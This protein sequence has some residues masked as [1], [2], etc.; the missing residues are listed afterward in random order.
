M[1]NTTELKPADK[2]KII[3]DKC[4]ASVH[5]GVNEHKSYYEPVEDYIAQRE[6]VIDADILNK[7]IE[8]DNLIE[9][10][11]YPDTPIGFY[12]IYHYDLDKALDE[13]LECLEHRIRG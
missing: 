12:K 2:L 11:L 10:Q 9:L 5:L 4:K 8:T 1:T 6:D 7:I 3:L 13:A